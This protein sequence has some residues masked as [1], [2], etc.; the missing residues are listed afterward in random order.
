MAGIII[1]I[2]G[3][4]LMP[5]WSSRKTLKEGKLNEILI[6]HGSVLAS[7]PGMLG[8]TARLLQALCVK[9]SA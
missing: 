3:E 8:N 4:L 6:E 7:P 2:S 1:L 5:V 9:I